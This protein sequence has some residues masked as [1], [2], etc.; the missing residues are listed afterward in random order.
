MNLIAW[1]LQ[2]WM[3]QDDLAEDPRRHLDENVLGKQVFN[4]QAGEFLRLPICRW[5]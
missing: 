5:N 1:P 3:S 4:A 2:P